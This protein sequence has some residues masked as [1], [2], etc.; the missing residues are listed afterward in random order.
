MK[1]QRKE[2]KQV[3]VAD[4][5]RDV[6]WVGGLDNDHCDKQTRVQCVFTPYYY[7]LDK[8]GHK[9]NYV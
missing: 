9:G 4:E 7:I 8:K 1:L 6:G 5:D 2:N 3:P